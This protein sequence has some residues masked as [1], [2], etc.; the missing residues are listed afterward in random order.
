[1]MA[2]F[3]PMRDRLPSL[4]RPDPGDRSLLAH[5][6]QAVG[7]SL[8]QLNQEASDVLQAHWFNVANRALYSPVFLRQ[9]QLRQQPFPRSTDPIL[10]T[11]PY[12]D[13]LAYLAALLN[14]APWQ[15]PPAQRE[16][17]EAYRDRIRQIV[18]LYRDGLATLNALRRMVKAQLPVNLM[19]PLPER[20]RGLFLEEF[21]LLAP[22]RHPIQA[23]GLPLELVGPLMRWSVH[24]PSVQPVPVTLYLQGVTPVAGQIDP[25]E[26]PVIELYQGQTDLP[27]GIAYQ[28]NLSAGQV[29]RLRPTLTSWLGTDTGVLRSPA[30]AI[31]TA[32][33]PLT[34]W[35]TA[36]EELTGS[37][38]AILQAG[39]RT[40]WLAHNIEGSGQLWRF[41]G[42]Q[43]Q[44]ILTDASLPPIH[45]LALAA[46]DLLIGSDRGLLR[47]PLFPVDNTWTPSPSPAGLNQPAVYAIASVNG[48][49]WLGTA[50]GVKTL[51]TGDTLQDRAL[52]G[53]PIYALH[54]DRNGLLFLAGDRG[55]F[56]FQPGLD[57]W[58]FYS[59]ASE[60][61][62]APEW[63][64]LNPNVPPAESAVHL[65][66]VR[67][68]CRGRDQSLWL[69]T[70]KGLARYVARAVQG[71]TYETALEAFP[72]LTTGPVYCIQAD[73]RGM[74]WFGCDRGLLR[75]DGRDMWQYQGDRWHP[76]GKA[77]TLYHADRSTQ[78]RGH[79]RFDRTAGEWQRPHPDPLAAPLTVRTQAE[80]AVHALLWTDGVVADLGEWQN[81]E[82]VAIAQATDP[83]SRLV[84]RY[85]LDAQRI[86]NGG[87]P[88]VPRLPVGHSTW[89]YLALEPTP[90]TEPD[91]KPAW[92]REG[93]LLPPPPTQ[94]VDPE[95]G[96]YDR[97]TPPP[98]SE[99]DRSLFAFNPSAQ[100]RF[101][102]AARRPLTVLAQV[103]LRSPSETLDPL[104]LQRV[105]QGIEQVRPAGVQVVL[106]VDEV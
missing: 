60:T 27:L 80:P 88:A 16:L 81:D 98:A 51:G 7:A 102:W 56:Q 31:T 106:N 71:L 50:T 11:Y 99:F 25:T 33:P 9:R 48:E 101:G 15:D 35:A 2:R 3:D 40:L 87:I 93:R 26:T 68:L 38:S 86:V 59:G 55:L 70:A 54:L 19:A 44:P 4:Y 53:S 1:M 47:L 10:D 28:G 41:D 90:F 39:D 58:Y 95:S 66:P 85:R 77:D 22:Q 105:A 69:G 63:A 14:I 62:Q 91:I 73:D 65:P 78:P 57:A 82:F 21:P 103:H 94:S 74:V 84:M 100:V 89:R 13:D 5:L 97:Q 96:R 23:P 29:L 45:C 30:Q 37:V 79:W 36:H 61:E 6:L 75:Y 46:Q 34:G 12:I 92:T 43:W 83:T 42:R 52:P 18:A 20:D 76:L 8:D 72:D 49:W 67:A 17:T 64:P 24:N 104:I 32:P